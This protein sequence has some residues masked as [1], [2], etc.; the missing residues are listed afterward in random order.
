MLSADVQNAAELVDGVL[1]LAVQTVALRHGRVEPF[2]KLINFVHDCGGR[3]R[4]W[5]AR[6]S[7]CPGA[8]RVANR[9]LPDAPLRPRADAQGRSLLVRRSAQ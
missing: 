3:T 5:L 9:V 6:V 7:R 1:R 8:D 4:W 2:R